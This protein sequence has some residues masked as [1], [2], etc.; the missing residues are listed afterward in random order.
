MTPETLKNVLEQIRKLFLQSLEPFERS[1]SKCQSI[2]LVDPLSCEA[3]ESFDAL[4]SKFARFFDIFGQRVLKSVALLLREDAP[5]S[6]DRINLSKIL[7][8]VPSTEILIRIRDLRN[9]IANKYA[10]ES[11]LE[12]YKETIALSGDLIR[13]IQQAD[14][15]INRMLH[16]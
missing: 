2:H 7:H 10:P 16:T 14:Q 1:L 8:L 9:L 11:L 6:I 3:E 13:A 5:T 4:T 12:V 15:T